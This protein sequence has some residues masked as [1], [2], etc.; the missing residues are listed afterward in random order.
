MK[1]GTANQNSFLLLMPLKLWLY[2]C[3]PFLLLRLW[4]IKNI[5]PLKTVCLTSSKDPD[6]RWPSCLSVD[7]GHPFRHKHYKWEICLS[8]KEG[9]GFKPCLQLQQFKLAFQHSQRPLWAKPLPS[10]GFEVQ[11]FYSLLMRENEIPGFDF[12]FWCCFIYQRHG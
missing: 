12:C 3:L 11:Y 9:L 1:S 2:K 7:T 4:A 5:T 8:G 6:S 10:T